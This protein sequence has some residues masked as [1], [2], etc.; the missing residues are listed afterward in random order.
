MINDPHDV[1]PLLEITQQEKELRKRMSPDDVAWV[2]SV[3]DDIVKD[4]LPTRLSLDALIE[5]HARIAV[6]EVQ[7]HG[8]H[9]VPTPDERNSLT[10]MRHILRTFAEAIGAVTAPTEDAALTARA[11]Q[12]SEGVEKDPRLA[13]VLVEMRHWAEEGC[14][15]SHD[16]TCCDPE[17]DLH[18]EDWCYRCLMG[19]VCQTAQTWQPI[20]T[21]PKN[22][23]EV[24]V[25][26]DGAIMVSSWLDDGQRAGWWDNGLMDPPP[27]HWMPLPPPPDA[28]TEPRETKADA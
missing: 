9:Y 7:N 12:A 4:L 1:P 15:G 6:L 20:E 8:D 17:M 16:G 21:A 5:K 24:L 2:R 25:Y 14:T 26:D 10:N 28:T 23:T 13:A 11:E 18:P 19:V 22:G 3:R 27:T